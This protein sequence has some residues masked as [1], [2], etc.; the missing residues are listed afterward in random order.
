MNEINLNTNYSNFNQPKAD[1]ETYAKQYAAENNLSLEEAKNELRAKFGDPKEGAQVP[2]LQ[3]ENQA[4]SI[5]S[6]NTSEDSYASISDI[7]FADF[8]DTSN[9][10][11]DNSNNFLKSMLNLF[12]NN[13]T[14]NIS[15]DEKAYRKDPDEYAQEYADANNITLEQAKKELKAQYGDP[16]E[17]EAA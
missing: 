6:S 4:A 15:N 10:S 14:S 8:E 7:D 12:K 16:K 11:N 3:Q 5:F 1:P 13:K 17:K 2:N 9:I